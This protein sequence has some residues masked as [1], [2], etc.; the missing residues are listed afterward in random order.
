MGRCGGACLA[1]VPDDF[2]ASHARMVGTLSDDIG[3]ER[4]GSSEASLFQVRRALELEFGTKVQGLPEHLQA[5]LFQVLLEAAG[6]P[7]VELPKWLHD[8]TTLGIA[9]Q[10]KPY[11]IVPKIEARQVGPEACKLERLHGGKAFDNVGYSTSSVTQHR[12]LLNIVGDSTS[13]VTQHL[14]PCPQSK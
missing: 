14:H 6:D 2:A 3:I 13:S 12:R 10:I 7:E 11:S 5:W 1:D 9:E 8:G 4:E